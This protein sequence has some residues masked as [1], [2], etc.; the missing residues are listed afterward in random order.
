MPQ[1]L[2]FADDH[3]TIS[4]GQGFGQPLRVRG[5]GQ[6]GLGQ[7]QDFHTPAK[8]LTLTRVRG[9][10]KGHSRVTFYLNCHLYGFKNKQLAQKWS[11]SD[12]PQGYKDKGKGKG[13]DFHTLVKTL[14]LGEGK[15]FGG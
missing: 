11:K 5:K 7:G 14:T 12:Q 4:D 2:Y 9:F 3:P 13:Q 6:E 10:C 8:P 1:D 15:G